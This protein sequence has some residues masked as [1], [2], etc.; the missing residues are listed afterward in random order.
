MAEEH[1]VLFGKLVRAA[2]WSLASGD[3][4]RGECCGPATNI[5]ILDR[6]VDVAAAT[7]S[8]GVMFA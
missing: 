6:N 8:M 3:A 2:P 1:A 7:S 5:V 4:R